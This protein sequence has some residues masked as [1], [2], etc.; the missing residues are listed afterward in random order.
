[1][2]RRKLRIAVVGCGSAGPAAA[3]LL[4]RAGHE[5]VVFERAPECRAVGAGFLLQPSG[6]A[7]LDELGI[8][9]AVLERAGKVERLHVVDRREKTVLDLRYAELGEG[10]FGAGLH[11]PVLLH[12]LLQ[13]LQVAGVEVRW[14]AEVADVVRCDDKWTLTMADG[15]REAGFDLLIVADGARSALRGKLGLQ[16]SDRGYAWGAHWFIG[17]NRGSFPE[18]DL[19]QIVQGTRKLAGFLAT[20]REVGGME[21]LVSLFW[22]VKLADDAAWRAKPLEE[23][24]ENVLALCPRS[25]ALLSQITDWSQILTARYGD[26]RMSRWHG[27]GVIVLGDAGH[28]MS[29]QLGQ[30]VN[31]ALADASCLAR[32]LEQ[33]PLND[34]LARYTQERRLTLA[35]Y[36]FATRALTPWFQSDYEWLTPI[37]HVYFRTMQHIPP[38]RRF[39]TKTMAGLV[40]WQEGG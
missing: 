7:V 30:G 22:S 34:A 14:G 19:H 21:P 31:L 29:P 17:E 40:G 3:T 37:R 5:V 9:G 16:G 15:G 32:C 13:A 39:M 11:R 36:R 12:F 35:Y 2:A 18:H 24:K 25:E 6:M 38:A 27:D 33:L 1:M 20:G 23:W 28:A 4:E 10:M 26:V 8:R